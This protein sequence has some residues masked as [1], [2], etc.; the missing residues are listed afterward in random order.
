M[1]AF[2]PVEPT[3]T[4]GS[5]LEGLSIHVRDHR[6]RRRSIGNRTR[7]AHYGRFVL[8]QARKGVEEALRLAL[9]VSY[10]H[11]PRQ[12]RVSGHAAHVY[13]LGPEPGPE[14]IDGRGPAVV[15]WH[16]GEMF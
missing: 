12:A 14:D 3:Y 5:T 6:L 9:D 15:A 4:A 16:D 7:E 10:G 11:A 2:R 1:L 13:D 8:S